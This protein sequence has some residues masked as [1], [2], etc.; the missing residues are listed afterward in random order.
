MWKIDHMHM[1]NTILMT[2]KSMNDARG[3]YE[4]R[5]E[6]PRVAKTP[7]ERGNKLLADAYRPLR[8]KGT[9]N[10]KRGR[11]DGDLRVK[12]VFKAPMATK[13]II[14]A[15]STTRIAMS[16]PKAQFQRYQ[17][18]FALEIEGMDPSEKFNHP[19][20]TMYDGKSNLR[21]HVCHFRQMMALWNYLNALMCRVFPS[22][23]GD[24]EWFNKLP[25]GAET[26]RSATIANGI[27]SS[28]TIEECLEELVVV[29]YKLGLTPSEKLWAD[30]TLD[31]PVDLRDLM[32]REFVGQEK[33]KAEET[34][35]RPNPRFDC[36]R[37]GADDALEEDLPPG[38]IHMIGGLNHPDLENRIGG[39]LHHQTNA[40]DLGYPTS[41]HREESST[42]IL[43]T[44]EPAPEGSEVRKE[45]PHGA[46]AHTI[47]NITEVLR[48]ARNHLRSII[49]RPEKSIKK[50]VVSQVIGKFEAWGAK[51]AKC[52]AI[53][54]TF[55]IEFIVIKIEQVGRNLNSH[56]DALACLVSVFEGKTGWTIVVDLISVPGHETINNLS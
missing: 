12:L 1:Q 47:E 54:K 23:L 53:A 41:A 15:R 42:R 10:A 40:R 46:E 6:H 52:L 28:T 31:P 33:T 26:R 34:K 25:P 39:D 4:A 13:T 38:I 45:P 29:N 43:A 20:F 55:L 30:L 24:L 44:T 8:A 17:T 48:F 9:T 14:P 21:S 2:S 56:A 36:N 3:N 7:Y 49:P 50:L 32:T 5:R 16:A 22:R 11:D 51:M 19:K 27:R 18:S 37:E 35:I